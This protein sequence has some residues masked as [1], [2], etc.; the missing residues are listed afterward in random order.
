MKSKDAD[1]LRDLA[2]SKDRS[3]D[4]VTKR[5]QDRAGEPMTD[6]SKNYAQE[7]LKEYEQELKE[8]D[9]GLSQRVMD[10]VMEGR[11]VEEMIEQIM[12][13]EI[14]KRLQEAIQVIKGE[15]EGSGREDVMQ[16][17]EE[18]ERLGL[19]SIKDGIVKITSKGARMLA[20]TTLE[21]VLC[22][23]SRQDMGGHSIEETGFG[24][25]LS[26]H[27]RPYELGDD[28]FLVDIEGTALNALER[29]G[30]LEL[31]T[32]DFQVF[33]PMHQSRLCVGLMIDESGSMGD[34]HKLRAAIET[35]LAL[36][37]LVRREPK[38]FLKVFIFSETVKEIP[39]WEIVNEMLGGGSTDIRAA[40]RA[41]RKA[42]VHEKGD[43]QAYIITDTD[44][45]TEDGRYVGFDKAMAGVI[46][47]AMHYRKHEISLNIVMLDNNPFLK[48]FASTL[49]RKNLGRTFFTYPWKLGEVLIED[50]LRSRKIRA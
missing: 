36:A 50:Y 33:E 17:L 44:P 40:M 15:Q 22:N 47:E 23:L 34:N 7:R 31:E 27:S 39:S 32:E 4:E 9:E 16:V 19:I 11:E 43:K 26:T 35:S 12:S 5:A 8:Y 10:D 45:N 18:Y 37:E 38:D 42:V 13:D 48:R 25:E 24:P 3:L 30:N 6:P 49:A 1:F 14:R 29:K 21:R 46:E 2:F 41:F 20:S 28:Y